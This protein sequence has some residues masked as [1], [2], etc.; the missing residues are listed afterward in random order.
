LE[1]YI[2]V[3]STAPVRDI[4]IDRSVTLFAVKHNKL[5]N[6]HNMGFYQYKRERERDREKGGNVDRF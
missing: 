2:P 1:K 3:S 6:G 4:A 5:R